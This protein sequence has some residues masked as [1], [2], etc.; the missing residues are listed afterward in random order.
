MSAGRGKAQG[1][2]GETAAG[3]TES[4]AMPNSEM[5]R[6]FMPLPVYVEADLGIVSRTGDAHAPA[7]RAGKAEFGQNGIGGTEGHL[8]ELDG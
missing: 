5:A 6:A 7:E 8:L 3:V 4:G 2:A 1:F